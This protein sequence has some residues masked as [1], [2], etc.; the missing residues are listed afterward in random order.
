MERLREVRAHLQAWERAFRRQRGRRPV[1]VRAA[2]G[3]E[4]A[5]AAPADALPSQEDVEVAPE[6][7]R[8]ER[9]A[10]GPPGGGTSGE[11]AKRAPPNPDP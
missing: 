10:A 9:R 6:E 8:G 1:Q 11:G 7:T 5:G 4:A 3:R 2:R